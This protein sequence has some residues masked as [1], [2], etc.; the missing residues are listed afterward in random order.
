MTFPAVPDP[1]PAAD[2]EH[3]QARRQPDQETLELATAG[4]AKVLGVEH[5][6]T[7]A[8]ARASITMAKV[9][10]WRGSGTTIT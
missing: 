9:D 4:A 5:S 7:K 2:R 10:L 3:E 6:V 8:L 1:D